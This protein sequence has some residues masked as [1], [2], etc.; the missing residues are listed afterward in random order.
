MNKIFVLVYPQVSL[1]CMEMDFDEF[2]SL[3]GRRHKTVRFIILS[4]KNLDGGLKRA[5][6]KYSDFLIFG[7][8][9]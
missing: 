5:E 8:F 3:S 9:D 2:T 4:D 1:D 6:Q 7:R